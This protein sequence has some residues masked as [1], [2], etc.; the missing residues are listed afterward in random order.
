M[1]QPVTPSLPLRAARR[2]RLSAFLALAALASCG[3]PEP[4][5]A[6]T[7][8]AQATAPAIQRPAGPERLVVAIGDS[9][10][11]GYGLKPGEAYPVKLEKALW[12][13]GV[14]ATLVNAGVSGD[15]TAA[16][17][18][19]L[20]FILDNQPRK[21]DLVILG[22]G[23]NDMLRALP[24]EEAKANLAAMLAELKRRDIPVLLTG[25]LAAPNLGPD[26]AAKFNAMY[27]ALAKQYGAALIPFFLQPVLGRADLIQA[28]HVHPTAPGIDL[29]VGATVDKV[30][31]ELA[32]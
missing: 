29:I 31:K 20:G 1:E 28:D 26:Y 24:P 4:G 19:R 23:G 6:P 30:A 25:M 22:F 17:R 15:T 10:Y 11:A 27:P 9:L 21:P 12:A 8:A 18:Q 7:A 16:G 3:G 13:K 32:A 5:V 2:L 14:N